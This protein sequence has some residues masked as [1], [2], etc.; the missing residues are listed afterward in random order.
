LLEI[1]EGNTNIYI[2]NIFMFILM[3]FQFINEFFKQR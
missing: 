2:S 3:N 1:T